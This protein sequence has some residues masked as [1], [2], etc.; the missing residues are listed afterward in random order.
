MADEWEQFAA[1]LKEMTERSSANLAQAANTQNVRRLVRGFTKAMRDQSQADI[2]AAL[3]A[4]VVE[5]IHRSGC[6][7]GEALTLV[8]TMF[9][10]IIN[11]MGRNPN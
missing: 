6:T 10:E 8:N 3:I 2:A 5:F 11:G 4:T 9:Q 1:E 7:P